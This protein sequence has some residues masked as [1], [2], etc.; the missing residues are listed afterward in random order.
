MDLDLQALERIALILFLLTALLAIR[1][2]ANPS[3]VSSLATSGLDGRDMG[4]VV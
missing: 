2:P 1:R 4:L 3:E